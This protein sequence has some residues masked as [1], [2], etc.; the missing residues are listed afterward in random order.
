VLRAGESNPVSARALAWL[1]KRRV[2]RFL[3]FQ[4]D[5]FPQNGGM[6]R[7]V[8]L[9]LVLAAALP[10]SSAHVGSHP[11][12]HD[13]VASVLERMK[14]Q[15]SREQLE[16]ITVEKIHGFL[17]AGEREILGSEHISFRA[18]VPVVVTVARGPSPAEDLFWLRERGF[19]KVDVA[20]RERGNELTVWQRNF[21][22]GW[23]GLGVNSLGGGGI[24]YIVTIAP[25]TAGQ[26]VTLTDLYPG[27]LRTAPLKPGVK[28]YV[29]RDET[30]TNIPPR[31]DGELLLRTQHA[32]RD[33]GR[34][35]NVLHWTEHPS[36]D[37]PDQVILTWSDDPKTTQAIQWRT[38]TKVQRGLA[39]YQKKSEVNPLLRRQP[40]PKEARARTDRIED[41]YTANDPVIHHHTAVLTG[42]EP[43]TTYLYTVG[44][45]QT[46]SEP[47]EFTTAPASTVPFSFVYMGDAQ[48]GLDRWG[49]LLQNAFR[50]RP[51]AA[52]YIMAGDLVNRGAD[53][54]DWDSLFHNA[55]GVYDRRQLVP[56]IGNHEYQGGN[57]SL[58]LKFF[59]LPKN[60]P[61][62]I[63]KEK[64]YSFK[65]SNA[66]FVILDSNLDPASQ[67]PWLENEL[68]RSRATWKFVV[69]HHPA[70]SSGPDRDNKKVR[71]L[72]TPIFDKYHVD[73]ALQG[74]DHAYL[75]T[76]PMKDQKRVASPAEGTVYIV[77]VSGTK[78]YKQDPRDYTEFGMTNVSTYQVLDVQIS[79]NRLVYRAYDLDGKLRDELVIEKAGR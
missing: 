21:E 69:Y 36:S 6:F 58:Y 7:S 46:W 48:N 63:E 34:L 2:T 45:G 24:H 11:S 8:L 77:S 16:K 79:G 31:L 18:N 40:R 26:E 55:R 54:D 59:E 38:S 75:R 17:T 22:A 47:A 29:D 19:E 71:E 70:Y 27:Q 33:D 50:S 56:A 53:R 57:P 12:V 49:S 30:L 3:L 14:R 44:A 32:R 66:L 20:W 25:R 76:Y 64:A 43:G 73:M 67:T 62:S 28:P 68:A 37:R 35:R 65:Y 72:W 1:A 10:R 5:G 4:F 41:K 78:M 15:M 52:F 60:G 39:R 42:L 9:T 13:T 51:D 74:H 23:I 61:A